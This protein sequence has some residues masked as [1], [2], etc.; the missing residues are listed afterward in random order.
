MESRGNSIL[1][2][3]IVYLVISWVAVL[4]RCWV[5]QRY[6]R[7]FWVDDWLLLISLVSW[8]S[9]VSWEDANGSTRLVVSFPVCV[10][11]QI[12]HQPWAHLLVIVSRF[13]TA[14]E[15]G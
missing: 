6:T 11:S 7:R 8:S 13:L 9:N 2:A 1:A 15:K 4:A 10:S 3:V 14:G 5:R 12:W